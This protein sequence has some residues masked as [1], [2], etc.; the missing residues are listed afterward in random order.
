MTSPTLPAGLV[1]SGRT[2][3]ISDP[4]GIPRTWTSNLFA[5]VSGAAVTAAALAAF[6]GGVRSLIE[7][8]APPLTW[9]VPLSTTVEQLA[10]ERPVRST[11]TIVQELRD[12]SG[13]T[14]DQLGRLLGVS[15]RAVHLWAAGGRVN[16]R[17]LE[18]LTKLHGIVDSLPAADAAQR[19]MLLFKPR[20]AEP[21]IFDTFLMQ[22]ASDAGT[23]SGT[24]FT[25]DQ[26]LGALHDE[27]GSD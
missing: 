25:P 9:P 22:H 26:L 2:S 6:T 5:T 10:E 8:T 23:V 3:P 27:N 18:L 15:R 24:P 7:R 1:L 4:A 21:S 16:A 11:A 20:Q 17:H 12:K 19:R 13:L 14:W